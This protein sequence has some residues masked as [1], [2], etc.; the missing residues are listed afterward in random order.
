MKYPSKLIPNSIETV[1][2]DANEIQI[3]K[4]N[5]ILEKWTGAPL[6]YSFGNKPLVKFQEQPMFAEMAIV[7][8]F[9]EEQWDVRWIETYGRPKLNPIFLTHWKDDE[10]KNQEH[11]EIKDER[12]LK[13]L[14]K[15]A[16]INL[17][18]FGGIWDV[19]A[20]K[21]ENIIFAECKRQK[22]DTIQSTQ[23]NWFKAAV[24]YGLTQ[25]NFLMIEW[26][27]AD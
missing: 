26:T 22:K 13:I 5:L 1:E 4:C 25:E 20:W 17:N 6:N 12:I 14:Q 24:E 9:Y 7:Q 18:K 3:P 19:V 10:L 23:K 27:F 16:K 2:I 15:I 21:N 11:V 8:L